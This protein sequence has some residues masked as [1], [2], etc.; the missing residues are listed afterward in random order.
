MAVKV[1]TVGTLSQGL[2]GGR[3]DLEAEGLTINQALRSLAT[4]LGQAAVFELYK[5]EVLRP[6]LSFLVNGRNVFGLPA[7]FDTKLN[8]GDELIIATV[9]AGG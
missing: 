2:P 5:N 4:R 6:G 1:I 9:V 7:Q 8:D 3:Y